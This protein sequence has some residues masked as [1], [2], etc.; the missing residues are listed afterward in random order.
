MR[1]G[2]GGGGGVP[3]ALSCA[4]APLRLDGP[5]PR[6]GV[7]RGERG[8]QVDEAQRIVQVR[9]RVVEVRVA[10]GD[11]VLQREGR[12]GDG[13]HAAGLAELAAADRACHTLQEGLHIPELGQ[14]RLMG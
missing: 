2:C 5:L 6:D 13:V 11:E 10:L 4:D 12:A 9:Q 8:K 14:Q 1:W 3:H 7:V